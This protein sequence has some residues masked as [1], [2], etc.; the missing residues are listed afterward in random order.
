M[1]TIPLLFDR[2]T[3]TLTAIQNENK[4]IFGV[5]VVLCIHFKK[6]KTSSIKLIQKVSSFRYAFVNFFHKFSPSTS[7]WIVLFFWFQLIRKLNTWNK[8]KRLEGK[9]TAHYFGLYAMTFFFLLCPLERIALC[10]TFSTY[11]YS[12]YALLT[13]RYSAIRI[14]Q[15]IRWLFSSVR[16]ARLFL[17]LSQFYSK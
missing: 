2:S 1:Y 13:C 7:Y 11:N 8:W 15:K 4:V 16:A 3:L 5:F 6:N 12:S 10:I 17:S 14:V 9:S